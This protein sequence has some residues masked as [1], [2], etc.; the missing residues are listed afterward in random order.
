MAVCAAGNSGVGPGVKRR[1]LCNIGR[2]LMSRN[3]LLVYR[4]G[5]AKHTVRRRGAASDDVIASE[6]AFQAKGGM[7]PASKLRRSDGTRRDFDVSN[8]PH[9]VAVYNLDHALSRS[10][11]E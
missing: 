7:T 6:A 9:H 4:K 8:F 11:P 2:V 5:R 1:F 10:D 3:R